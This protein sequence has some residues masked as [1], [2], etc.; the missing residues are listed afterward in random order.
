MLALLLATVPGGAQAPSDSAE[1]TVEPYEAY[2]EG[3]RWDYASWERDADADGVDDLIGAVA[4]SGLDALPRR[5]DGSL[6]FLARASDAG[7]VM[8]IHIAFEAGVGGSDLDALRALGLDDLRVDSMLPSVWAVGA[9]PEQATAAARLPGVVMVELEQALRALNNVA[10]KA[11]QVED[12]STYADG[13]WDDLG[14]TGDGIGIAILDTGV[15]DNHRFLRN[16]FVAGADT[17]AGGCTVNVDVNPDDDNHAGIISVLTY[18]GTHVAATALGHGDTSSGGNHAGMAKDADLYDVKVLTSPGFS[19]L[20]SVRN[21]LV[22]V[23]QFNQGNTLWHNPLHPGHVAGTPRIDIVS[24]SL[25][26]ACSDGNDALSQSV[27]WLVG[28]GVTVVVA[29]GNDGAQSSTAGA[30]CITSPS[31]AAKAISV[32]AYDD[33]GSADRSGDDVAG[34]SNCGPTHYPSPTSDQKKPDV[35]APGVSIGSAAGDATYQGIEDSVLV[36]ALSGTSMATPVVAGIAA[37]MLEKDPTLT[38]A[39]IK[40]TLRST[41]EFKSSGIGFTLGSD[42]HSCWGFGQVNAYDAV[43][44]V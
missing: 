23:D 18:H 4:A 28:K 9:T 36:Q 26:G 16:R 30:G 43:S 15:D 32:G 33:K 20:N 10:R 41:A 37:L 14:Y 2:D 29:V 13:V 35:T 40:S 22:W 7:P 8:D 31:A 42:Y 3:F 25:G 38:P 24:M 6:P 34:F 21:G 1:R 39:G 44:A 12:S 11:T 5:A 17:T 27:D 19:C